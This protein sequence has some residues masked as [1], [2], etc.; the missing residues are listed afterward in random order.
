MSEDAEKVAWISQ[1][2]GCSYRV[3]T[4]WIRMMMLSDMNETKL[5]F[6]DSYSLSW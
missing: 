2:L 6:T 4:L 3:V 1:T 5:R